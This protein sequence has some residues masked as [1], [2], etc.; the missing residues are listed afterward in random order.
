MPGE[1]SGVLTDEEKGRLR[2]HLGYIGTQP[3]T[4]IVLGVQGSTQ[5]QFLIEGAMNRIPVSQMGLVRR[6][7]GILDSIEALQVEA[8]ERLA[9]DRL[10]D[11]TLNRGE[12]DDIE[13]E[14]T[15]WA[16]KVADFLGCPLNPYAQR[17]RDSAGKAPL[18]IPVRR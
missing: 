4:N 8:L 16:Q 11:I 10:G 6:W 13:K 18:N 14:H 7:L 9:A 1:N 17:F 3:A 2:S 5:V 15:R 12:M